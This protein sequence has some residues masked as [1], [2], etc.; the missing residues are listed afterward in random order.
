MGWPR[1]ATVTIADNDGTSATTQPPFVRL[2]APQNGAQFA[3]PTN[4]VLRAYAQDPEDGYTLTVEF[5]EDSRSLGL[6]TF[7]PGRC[8]TCP[9]YELTWSN[10]PP[11]SYGVSAKVTDSGGFWFVFLTEHTNGSPS[12]NPPRG[13][14][15]FPPPNPTP[16]TATAYRAP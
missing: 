10:V 3:G 6:G 8:V 2:D 4:I 15:Y 7:V 12:H 11:G 14:T 5:F 13:K 16:Q 1:N 9:Y